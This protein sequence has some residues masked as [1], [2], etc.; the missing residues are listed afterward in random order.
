MAV[1]ASGA[2]SRFALVEAV[3]RWSVIVTSSCGAAFGDLLYRGIAE[4]SNWKQFTLALSLVLLAVVTVIEPVFEGVRATLTGLP[5]EISSVERHASR[6]RRVGLGLIAAVALILHEMIHTA[7]S[8]ETEEH[9]L[10][11]LLILGVITEGLA[12][13]TI[14]M[15][16]AVPLGQV[17][18]AIVGDAMRFGCI[19]WVGGVIISKAPGPR[20]A[21][22]VA[23]G[24]FTTMACFLA[25]GVWLAGQPDRDATLS[26]LSF[27][28]FWSLALAFCP[29]ADTALAADSLPAHEPS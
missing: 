27:A 20:V 19:G 12:D 5:S 23:L 24:I 11:S 7:L 22:K 21:C 3:R 2:E 29:H 6:L 17:L 26:A 10:A 9:Q 15:V 25:L 13:S 14:Y 28:A 1:G 8:T 4:I 18:W 16:A